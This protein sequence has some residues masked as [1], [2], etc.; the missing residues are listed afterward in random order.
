MINRR[1]IMVLGAAAAIVPAIPVFALEPANIAEIFCRHLVSLGVMPVFNEED[2]KFT[3]VGAKITDKMAS[4]SL[5]IQRHLD[6]SDPIIDGVQQKTEASEG[7]LYALASN[8]AKSIYPARE[9]KTFSL[10]MPSDP[11]EGGLVSFGHLKLRTL[12]LYQPY[13]MVSDE[14]EEFMDESGEHMLNRI[15]ILF[16]STGV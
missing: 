16:P 12:R 2:A 14:G 5:L 4:G 6:W 8:V 7:G 13:W 9:L 10:F 3:G 15:D 11:Y 1:E